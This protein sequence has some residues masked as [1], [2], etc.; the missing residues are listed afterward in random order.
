M[1]CSLF[2]KLA[3]TIKDFNFFLI[4]CR[5][6]LRLIHRLFLHLLRDIL[7]HYRHG[8][9]LGRCL[10][11]RGQ[12]RWRGRR[13]RVWGCE[14]QAWIVFDIPEWSFV[15]YSRFFSSI[16][17][18]FVPLELSKIN[19]VNLPAPLSLYLRGYPLL[20]SVARPP[21]LRITQFPQTV[22]KECI[23]RRLNRAVIT[24]ILWL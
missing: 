15:F 1:L 11:N 16:C 22:I 20:H 6:R 21:T 19:L 4:G 17:L 12:R 3:D 13:L 24:T 18:R 7:R 23:E 9:E 5:L 14:E 10:G 2:L 8:L